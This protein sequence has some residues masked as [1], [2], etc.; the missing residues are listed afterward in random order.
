MYRQTI[1]GI[2][3]LE[4]LRLEDGKRYRINHNNN[5]YIFRYYAMPS[6]C[7]HFH[8]DSIQSF[9]NNKGFEEPLAALINQI[10][11]IT[12]AFT[13]GVTLTYEENIELISRS[14]TLISAAVIPTG[15]GD[16]FQYHCTYSTKE[17]DYSDRIE[18]FLKK[19]NKGITVKEVVVEK[20]KELPNGYVAVPLERL[21]KIRDCKTIKWKNRHMDK[22]LDN[23]NLG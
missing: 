20:E 19:E 7:K 6:N 21:Q 9:I 17:N 12:G 2:D 10:K 1:N 22:V 16:R 4:N 15:Y 11:N 5:S 3:D 8:L 23:V 13:F 18:K 14:A